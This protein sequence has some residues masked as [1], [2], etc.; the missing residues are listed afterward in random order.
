MIFDFL[1]TLGIFDWT[2]RL[3]V[4]SDITVQALFCTL[5]VLPVAV[6]LLCCCATAMMGDPVRFWQTFGWGTGVVICAFTGVFFNVFLKQSGV[7]TDFGAHTGAQWVPKLFWIL[8]QLPGLFFI[9]VYGVVSLLKLLARATKA[10]N[11]FVKGLGVAAVWLITGSLLLY[12][13]ELFSPCTAYTQ[14]YEWVCD[15]V[16]NISGPYDECVGGSLQPV[17][18]CIEHEQMG[19]R[20]PITY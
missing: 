7:L 10:R 18:V 20:W 6:L 1:Y 4:P 11:K 13:L 12:L 14:G 3:D 8:L 17:D 5:F 9:P 16:V 15:R 2:A 19:V